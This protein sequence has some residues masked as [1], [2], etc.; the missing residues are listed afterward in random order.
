MLDRGWQL[1]MF[2]F[3]EKHSLEGAIRRLR[4]NSTHRAAWPR[5]TCSTTSRTTC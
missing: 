4:K 3:R 1:K 2:E 5:S